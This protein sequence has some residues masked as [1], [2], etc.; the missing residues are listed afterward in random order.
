M[1]RLRRSGFA[2]L[3][4]SL[5]D[6]LYAPNSYNADAWDHRPSTESIRNE[7]GDPGSDYYNG[8]RYAVPYTHQRDTST[9]SMLPEDAMRYDDDPRYR[10][11]GQYEYDQE[12]MEDPRYAN[13]SGGEYMEYPEGVMR[14][15]DP[16]ATP[17]MGEYSDS[18]AYARRS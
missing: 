16:E 7:S 9:T 12:H 2:V 14:G 8:E 15:R 10:K 18:Q 13:A 1:F 4:Q 6:S 3:H 11:E 5:T 17:R